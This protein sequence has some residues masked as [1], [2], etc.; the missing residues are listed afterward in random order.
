MLTSNVPSEPRRLATAS[1]AVTTSRLLKVWRAAAVLVDRAEQIGD[2]EYR[3]GVG[4]LMSLRH[5]VEG[6]S[7]KVNKEVTK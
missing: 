1:E 7:D 6:A 2:R 3:L 4:D 5:A